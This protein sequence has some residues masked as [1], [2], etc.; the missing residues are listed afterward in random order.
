M[1]D[2]PSRLIK[3]PI[4]S[5]ND[6]DKKGAFLES[7]RAYQ[8]LE[9][10]PDLRPCKIF[11]DF[12]TDGYYEVEYVK[13]EFDL[14]DLESLASIR[15]IIAKMVADPDQY[16]IHDFFPRNV[17]KGEDG[18][19][20]VIDLADREYKLSGVDKEDKNLNM[21]DLAEDISK[22]IL[23]W[24]NGDKKS[25]ELF[26]NEIKNLKSHEGLLDLIS[27]RISSEI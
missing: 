17:R 8:K 13:E 5:I 12:L 2:Q 9:D 6:N 24:S 14:E 27:N 3:A 11:N 1:P 22:F 16:F 26:M 10:H 21:E 7:A 19:V 23:K 20:V 4:G 25:L 15:Q 18:E